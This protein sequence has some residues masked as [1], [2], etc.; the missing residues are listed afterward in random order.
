M[1]KSHVFWVGLWL[2][3]ITSASIASS[4]V[5]IYFML[6]IDRPEVVKAM[7]SEL[8][9]KVPGIVSKQNGDKVGYFFHLT[10]VLGVSQKPE[11]FFMPREMVNERLNAYV[12]LYRVQINAPKEERLLPRE[13]H[14]FNGNINYLVS[15]G[16]VPSSAKKVFVLFSDMDILDKERNIYS[17]GKA[18]GDGWIMSE[19]SPFRTFLLNQDNNFI[20]NS[21]IIIIGSRR[22]SLFVRRHKEDFYTKLFAQINSRVFYAGPIYQSDLLANYVSA[23]L[24]G[25]IQPLDKRDIV[26]TGVLQFLTYSGIETVN[27]Y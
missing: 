9:K 24:R 27:V 14:L 8:I 17:S 26:P 21:D 6:D 7:D 15:K 19:K 25:E 18:L 10:K 13:I 11:L 16:L 22:E 2:S 20:S 5:L 23:V 4:D 1:F 12:S 3:T